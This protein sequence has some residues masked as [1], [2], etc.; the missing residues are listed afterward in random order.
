MGLGMGIV[1]LAAQ[2]GSFWERMCPNSEGS[3]IWPRRESCQ[4]ASRPCWV[5]RSRMTCPRGRTPWMGKCWL[6]FLPCCLQ[7]HTGA[8]CLLYIKSGCCCFGLQIQSQWYC[9]FWAS[10]YPQLF[11]FGLYSSLDI[12]FIAGQRSCWTPACFYLELLHFRELECGFHTPSAWAPVVLRLRAD[13]TAQNFWFL[14]WQHIELPDKSEWP[15]FE[16]SRGEASSASIRAAF[17]HALPLIP[18]FSA[19]I[20][21]PPN[22]ALETLSRQLESENSGEYSPD[23]R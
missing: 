19:A 4:S 2:L 16:I 14:L 23:L 9:S 18:S 22:S 11:Y 7:T 10:P 17:L 1:R 12:V 20:P 21:S 6:L 5:H 8:S 13:D 15:S 3:Q